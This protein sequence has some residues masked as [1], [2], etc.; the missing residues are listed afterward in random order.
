MMPIWRSTVLVAV[1][2]TLLPLPV[3]A[4]DGTHGRL[5]RL[6]A[7]NDLEALPLSDD[8][9]T[10]V[11]SIET[12]HVAGLIA[13]RR[14]IMLRHIELRQ[15]LRDPLSDEIKVRAKAGEIGELQQRFRD[16]MID[17][18]LAIRAMLTPEQLARWCT[19]VNVGWPSRGWGPHP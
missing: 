2:L 9:R 3:S 17:Y 11:R 6:N 16:R 12:G 13:L 7:C 8:Q 1:L 14:D 19:M 5:G 15:L 4:R 18:Q 10:A